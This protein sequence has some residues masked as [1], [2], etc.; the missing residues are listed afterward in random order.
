MS[1]RPV[2]AVANATGLLGSAV[3]K[4]IANDPLQAARVRAL[5]RLPGSPAARAL[6]DAGAEVVATEMDDTHSVLRSLRGAK[7]LVAVT[8]FW[9]HGSPERELSQ[10]RAMATA[11]RLADLEHVIWLTQEDSRRWMSLDDTRMPTLLQRYKVPPF[12]AKGEADAFFG[13][14][15]IPVTFLRTALAWEQLLG[16]GMGPRRAEDGALRLALPLGERL[17]P[18]IAANDIGM[19]VRRL[20]LDA[21]PA[22]LRTIGVAAAH[23][24]GRDMALAF[25]R[26]LHESVVFDAVSFDSLRSLGVPGADEL[27]NLFQFIHDF[28][29]AYVAQRSV[30]ATRTLHPGTQ[31]MDEWLTHHRAYI[32]SL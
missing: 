20:L 6:A 15:G 16:F 19:V 23:L 2:V 32:P 9:E 14:M 1:P 12:D 24:T 4:A 22:S 3:V 21:P 28:N 17:L 5:V 27:G 8:D 30:E 25:Q 10:A 26:A 7:A 13:A 31:S 29:E 11:A 18:G